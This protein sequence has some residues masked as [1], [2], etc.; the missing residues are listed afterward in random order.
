MAGGMSLPLLL[1][2]LQILKVL[3]QL[4][5]HGNL[6]DTGPVNAQ[7]AVPL[8]HF[9]YILFDLHLFGL[10]HYFGATLISCGKISIRV[11]YAILVLS[12]VV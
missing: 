4:S 12:A 6:H 3:F 10:R 9:E 7:I 11:W 2:L 5:S 1:G 8:L